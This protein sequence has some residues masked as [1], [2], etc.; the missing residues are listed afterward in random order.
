MFDMPESEEDYEAK[1]A[2]ETLFRAE[3]I[4]EDEDLVERVQKEIERKTNILASIRDSLYPM[5]E[6]ADDEASF[7]SASFD[8]NDFFARL[9]TAKKKQE[10]QQAETPAE[11]RR[12]IYKKREPI[13]GGVVVSKFS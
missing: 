7:A 5:D 10:R 1:S 9:Q 8:M 11:R 12:R 3:E 6:T 4:R 13:I 2:L